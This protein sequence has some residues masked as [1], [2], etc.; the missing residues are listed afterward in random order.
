MQEYCSVTSTLADTKAFA[1][2]LKNRITKGYKRKPPKLRYLPVENPAD[3]EKREEAKDRDPDATTSESDE[4]NQMRRFLR[5]ALQA[6]YSAEG[7]AEMRGRPIPAAPNF[8]DAVDDDDE[9]GDDGIEDDHQLRGRGVGRDDGS[10]D[11]GV[12]DV[13]VD[14]RYEALPSAG[15]GLLG[16]RLSL[17][18][19]DEID[20]DDDE[21]DAYVMPNGGNIWNDRQKAEMESIIM[22]LESENV[23][24]M[25]EIEKMHHFAND[26][27]VR[28]RGRP[29]SSYVLILT[30]SRF[31]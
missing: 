30:T 14:D 21:E 8:D 11:E 10:D 12:E 6:K 16:R 7:I 4:V 17:A 26:S 31:F 1:K 28:K 15:G 2:T 27:T 20:D 9:E 23:N 24:L 22:H 13:E 5:E 18:N 19:D 25:G 29:R 3:G